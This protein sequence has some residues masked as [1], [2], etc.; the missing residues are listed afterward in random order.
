MCVTNNP[1]IIKGAQ[2]GLPID[3]ANRKAS[4]SRVEESTLFEADILSLNTK[5]G[6]ITN[7]STTIYAMLPL[8][9]ENSK[10]YYELIKRLK[11]CRFLQGQEIDRVKGLIA[12]K[13]PVHWTRWNKK[14]NSAIPEKDVDFYNT[15]LCDK[16]AY[17]MRWLYS[18]Y[19]K[20][21]TKHIKKYNQIS[22]IRYGKHLEEIISNPLNQE[23]EDFIKRYYRYN[24]L[25]DSD[26]VMNRICHHMEDSVKLL[27]ETMSRKRQDL[28]FLLKS[29]N[30]MT[31][32]KKLD[33]IYRE[34]RAEKI[35]FSQIKLESGENKF[36]TIEQYNKHVRQKALL[37]SSDIS[38]LANVAVDICY[39][40]NKNDGKNFVWTI[41]GEGI[42]NNLRDKVDDFILI[43]FLDENGTIE[44]LGERY[45]LKKIN[46]KKEVFEYAEDI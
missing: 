38:E 12:K 41:F 33:E 10:E 28:S 21:Y 43:P 34:Y 44:Y 37:I 14:D 16:R 4:K 22:F 2:I 11:Y 8:Y 26:C 45:S 9:R 46:P 31:I 40:I 32:Y 13:F 19:N 7:T 30:D 24:P 35:I 6:Y 18:D 29:N 27:K 15:V 3:Y 5:I 1:I 42:I 25:L 20:E 23:Q 36:S 17:F 39:V